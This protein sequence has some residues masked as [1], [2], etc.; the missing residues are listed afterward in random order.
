VHVRRTSSP[1][2][3][4]EALN[5]RLTA[6]GEPPVRLVP[7]SEDLENEDL[8]EMVNSGLL[9]IT[10]CD[11]YTVSFWKHFYPALRFDPRVAVSRGGS[12][13]WMMRKDSPQL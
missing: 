3:R 6:E 5:A 11:G 9:P 1:W 4:I 8:L 2:E 13:A 7:V 10:V 12:V